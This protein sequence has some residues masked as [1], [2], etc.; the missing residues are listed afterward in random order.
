MEDKLSIKVNVA[1][2]YYPLRIEKEEEESIRKAARLINEKVLQY[3]QRY[4]DKD[5]QD[6]MAM[7]ALQYV[8][9]ALEIENNNDTAPYIEALNA[10]D[11]KLENILAEE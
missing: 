4:S 7:T 3:K 11:K 2:R 9:K 10:L 6:F 8:I 5:V 1:E